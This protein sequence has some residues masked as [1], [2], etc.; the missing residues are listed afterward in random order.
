MLD[1]IPW[2]ISYLQNRLLIDLKRAEN[3]FVLNGR[4][5][6]NPVA[7]LLATAKAYDGDLEKA[8]DRIIDSAYGQVPEKHL[9]CTLEI[10]R[11]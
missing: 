11:Y 10:L 1:D 4:T 6:T 8:V 2:L 5:G 7:G 3:D 9:I